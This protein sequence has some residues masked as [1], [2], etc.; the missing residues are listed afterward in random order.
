MYAIHH[1]LAIKN[2]V[3]PT[4]PQKTAALYDRQWATAI[5]QGTKPTQAR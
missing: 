5:S 2:I 1:M 3:P 4:H